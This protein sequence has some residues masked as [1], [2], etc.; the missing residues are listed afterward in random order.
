MSFAPSVWTSFP[1]LDISVRHVRVGTWN[2]RVLETGS[3]DETVVLLPGTGGHLEAYAHNLAAFAQ[4]YR[5]SPTTTPATA[6]PPSPIT[7]SSYTTTSSTCS[8]CSTHS[9][10]IGRTSTASR[11]AVGW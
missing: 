6:T 9:A 11:W 5:G 1:G 3:G 2:T 10:L 4:Q 8:V 7:T